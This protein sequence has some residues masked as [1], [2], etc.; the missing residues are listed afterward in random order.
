MTDNL[1]QRISSK[2]ARVAVIGLGAMGLPPV[3]DARLRA[4][5]RRGW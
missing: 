5:A 2:T 4:T 1:Q 3:A